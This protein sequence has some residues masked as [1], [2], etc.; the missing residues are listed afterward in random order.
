MNKNPF[1]TRIK[2]FLYV[3][4]AILTMGTGVATAQIADAIQRFDDR[5]IANLAKTR[6]PQ[7]TELFLFLS[8]SAP[9]TELA[10]PTGLFIG[11]AIANDKGMRENAAYI[12]SSAAI[13]LGLTLLIKQ[14]EKR[15]RPYIRNLEFIPVYKETY[16]SF[17]S[18]HASSS[19]S[20]AT[21]LS[22]A[23]PK[24]YV[25]APSFLWAGSV[26]YSRVYLGV[27]YPS[28]IVGGAM[29]GTATSLSMSFMKN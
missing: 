14:F 28:D 10:L 13:N 16:Y 20:A 9:Y 2:A 15:R 6:T 17:P 5:A 21:A 12:A 11:G 18:G 4:I 24:W 3:Q 19:F 27:H 26:S 22:M 1:T 7:R 23:Y 29:L 8:H 25:I